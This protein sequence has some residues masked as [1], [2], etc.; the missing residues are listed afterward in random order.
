MPYRLIYGSNT[1]Q[2]ADS[3][4]NTTTPTLFASAVAFGVN[5][6]GT[7]DTTSGGVNAGRVFRLRADGYLST[8]A[9]AST[10]LFKV[11][12]GAT[13]I[14]ISTPAGLIAPISL[15]NADWNLALNIVI[16]NASATGK[17]MCQGNGYIND[18]ITAPTKPVPITFGL[19]NVG[20][21]S[22]GQVAVN[23]QLQ[24]NLGVQVT[25][26]TAGVG[27]TIVMSQLIVEQLK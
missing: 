20:T 26:G 5:T 13:Q 16:A 14:A 23:T 18:S 1:V 4:T 17:I 24:A 8:A 22:A 21:V 3:I 25:F 15:V 10:M 19:V 27:N 6:D 2:A 7:S 9:A 11:F 12:W